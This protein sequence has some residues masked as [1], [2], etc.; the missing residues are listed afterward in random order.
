MSKNSKR[1]NRLKHYKILWE[2]SEASPIIR[3]Y[4]AMN[5]FDG[6]LTALGIVLAGF[7]FWL[8]DSTMQTSGYLFFSGL[9]TAIAIGIS[10]LT[11]SH[12]AESAERNLN[13]I[14]MKQV[15]GLLDSEGNERSEDPDQPRYSDRDIKLALGKFE[16]IS[17]Y[18]IG[19]KYHRTSMIPK[20]NI[21]LEKSQKNNIDFN[22]GS[23]ELQDD[24]NNSELNQEKPINKKNKKKSKTNKEP[25]TMFEE[26][27]DFAGKV[28]A[29]VDGFS[30]FA[31]VIIVVLPFLFGDPS[32]PASLVQYIFSF[33]FSVIVLFLLGSYLARLSRESI[34][35][36]GLQMVAA[37]L[38]TG[39]LTVFFNWLLNSNF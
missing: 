28:A 33:A 18:S 13:V 21:P 20:K 17:T 1:D 29:F 12:L 25:K 11:G 31:G 36:F 7:A 9:T 14:Q 30:P 4:F 38:F 24:Q 26:A 34:L 19:K 2:I 22:G 6:I 37:A 10:G 15:L 5:F 32:Q 23:E 27:Q 16:E 39:I 35:K 8:T 3:R